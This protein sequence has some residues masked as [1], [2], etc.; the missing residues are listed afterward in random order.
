MPILLSLILVIATFLRSFGITSTPPELFGDELDVG[1]QAYSLFKTGRDLYR[2]PLPFYLKSL[3]EPRLPLL[4]YATVPGVATL[5]LTPVSTRLPEIIFGSLAPVIIFFLT[6]QLTGSKKIAIWSA[7]ALTFIPV[8]IHYSR[9]AYEVAL[10]LDLVMLGTVFW[11]RRKFSLSLLFFALGLYTYSTATVFVPLLLIW[12]MMKTSLKKV[13][14]SLVLFLILIS[15]YLYYLFNGTATNRFSQINILKTNDV[16]D[17]V[18][19]LKNE[20]DFKYERYFTNTYV[21][22][23]KKILS[24]YLSAFTPEF[25]FLTGDPNL[26]Q[27][28]QTS[29]LLFPALIPFLA[30][31]LFTAARKKWWLLFFWLLI[32]PLPASVTA[33]GAR[34]ATRMFYLTTPLAVLVGIGASAL[35]NKKYLLYPLLLISLLNF[36][37][38]GEYYLVHYPKISWRF[39][40]YGYREAFSDMQ[41]LSRPYSQ[42]FINNTYEPSL[43]RFLFYYQYPPALFHSQFTLDQPVQNI[44]PNYNGFTLGGGVGP[45]YIFGTFDGSINKNNLESYLQPNALYLL[46][47]QNEVPAGQ[48]WRTNKPAGITVLSTI[49]NPYD[50]PL[51]YLVTKSE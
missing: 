14:S 25:L 35:I 6:R 34:H 12:L 39:W 41:K 51:F 50:A 31:G 37:H 32:S 22:T 8:A 15:P 24:N 33:D 47:A 26:R 45:Q 10:L 49:A 48:D 19:N 20:T 27:S 38:V 21:Y 4:I 1:Y 9:S 28:V 7:L 29:G 40:H 30:V 5:G 13:F 11:L 36:V 46:S 16:I 2:Q 23:A 44:A 42:I 43:I 17:F 3:S 18:F